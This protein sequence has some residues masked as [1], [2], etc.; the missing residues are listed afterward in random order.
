MVSSGYTGLP[1]TASGAKATGWGGAPVFDPARFNR[2]IMHGVAAVSR[3]PSGLSSTREAGRAS[4][5]DYI[6]VERAM[7]TTT[8]KSRLW[9]HRSP[10]LVGPDGGVGVKKVEIGALQVAGRGGCICI[11]V[12]KIRPRAVRAQKAPILTAF[13]FLASTP[14]SA[15]P[16][17]GDSLW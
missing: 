8:N 12:S 13:F 11:A 6:A 9:V 17:S 15:T 4:T 5:P 16:A 3:L 7:K 14:Q 1:D 10:W 2:P